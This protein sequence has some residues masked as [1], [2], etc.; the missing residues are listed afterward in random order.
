MSLTNSFVFPRPLLNY[1]PEG[2]AA[3]FVG[4][5]SATE[6]TAHYYPE[7]LKS[8]AVID[9]VPEELPEANMA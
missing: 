6:R 8:A 3:G 2:L 9:V 7:G 4:G 1:A 5:V